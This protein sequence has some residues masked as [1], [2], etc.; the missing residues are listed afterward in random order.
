VRT[1]TNG[2]LFREHDRP[3]FAS[4]MADLAKILVASGFNAFWISVDSAD[5]DLHEINRGLPGVIQGI[6]KA[7]PILHDHGL[8]PA[9]NLG[10]NRLTG[11]PDGPP[12]TIR[13]IRQPLTPPPSPLI[14]AR[15]FA[16]STPLW[17]PSDSPRSTPAIP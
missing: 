14:S 1:G 4:R 7:L 16:V 6:K 15:P 10:I 2:F 5:A 13:P 9:A 12:P 11:G 17:N 3:D 8:F